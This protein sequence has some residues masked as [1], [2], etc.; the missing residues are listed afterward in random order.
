M[1]ERFREFWH[2]VFAPIGDLL[3]RMH[4]TPDMVTY[5]GTAGVSFGALFFY[6]KGHFL[7]GTLFITAFVFSD[8]IDGYMARASGQSSKWGAFLDSSL[9]RV[10]DA[11]I[12]A[13]LA[14]WYA[15][16]GDSQTYLVLSLVCLVLGMLTSYT[17]ARAE[18][19]G[20]DAKGGIAERSD[21]LV[22]ILAMAGLS[23]L[24]GWPFLLELTLWV[25]TVASAVTVVQRML[26]VRQQAFA[27]A[28]GTPT[29]E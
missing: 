24:F 26:K 5:T 6:P 23:G 21:R 1:L 3:L 14:L 29:E 2:R 25:L 20:F 7:V 28:A 17:R 18:G 9:D 15:G 8:I 27:E 11:A 19:L 4:V 12:F 22:A 10:A 13:G 16:R